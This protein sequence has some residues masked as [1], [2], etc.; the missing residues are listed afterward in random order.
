[1]CVLK[2]IIVVNIMW[3]LGE[4]RNSYTEQLKTPPTF[5]F[6]LV[7]FLQEKIWCAPLFGFWKLKGKSAAVFFRIMSPFLCTIIS[8]TGYTMWK[9]NTLDTYAQMK[10]KWTDNFA[11]KIVISCTWKQ[12]KN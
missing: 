1:M 4:E 2:Q 6:K 9:K 10:L 8:C 7:P 3:L 11:V 12:S 5:R